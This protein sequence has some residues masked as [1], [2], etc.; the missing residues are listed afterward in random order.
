M[1]VRGEDG[2]DTG[3]PLDFMGRVVVLR[4]D[5]AARDEDG[6][7]WTP[8]RFLMRGPRAPRAGEHVILM[9]EGGDGSCIGR[10]ESI[11]GWKACVKPDLATWDGPGSPPPR[12]I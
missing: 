11:T 9:H 1:E 6:C 8:V 7:I 10:V 5:I 4:A 3:K 12:T 2:L